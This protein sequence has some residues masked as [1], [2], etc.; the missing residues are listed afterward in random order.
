M[1]S[2]TLKAAQTI[3]N[4]ILDQATAAG[5]KPLT[6]LVADMGGTQI[7]LV[8]QD[9]CGIKRPKLANAKV[10]AALALNMPT[11]TLVQFREKEPALHAILAKTVDDPLLPLKG[12]VLIEDQNGHIL[13]AVGVTGGDLDAEE[14]F[15]IT[16]IKAAGF[17]PNPPE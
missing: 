10:S 14:G 1:T 17:L 8:R 6:I 7:A 4:L 5:S 12:G 2:L 9:G 15:A 3:I 16:A 11:R 13:G